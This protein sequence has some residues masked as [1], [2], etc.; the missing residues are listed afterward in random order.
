[1]LI[2]SSQIETRNQ[3]LSAKDLFPLE[4]K[5]TKADTVYSL[6]LRLQY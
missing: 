5:P 1:M 2:V 4:T 6:K 3:A